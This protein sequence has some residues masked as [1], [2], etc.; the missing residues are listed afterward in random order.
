VAIFRE[1]GDCEGL[2][3]ALDRLAQ[4]AYYAGDLSRAIGLHEE[5]LALR[6]ESG[7][8][9]LIGSTL[10]NLGV[11][12]HE[13]GDPERALPLIAEA[14]ALVGQ[15]GNT[16]M[17]ARMQLNLG[18]VQ[19]SLGNVARAAEW[20]AHS[21]ALSWSCNDLF[22]I[23]W[24]L[25]AIATLLIPSNPAQAARLFGKAAALVGQ[26]DWQLPPF[27]RQRLD[28]ALDELRARLDPATHTLAWQTGALADLAAIVAEAAQGAAVLSRLAPPAG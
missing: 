5:V 22:A 19:M 26:D 8:L 10:N 21:L 27:D 12:I 3:D 24:L 15:V 13:N 20:Y 14:V 28:T 23:G 17:R 1:L 25:R 7:D 11:A 4:C 18:S 2:G 9:W 6:R 16:L